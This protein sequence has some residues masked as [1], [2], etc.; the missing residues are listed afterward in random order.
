M[1]DDIAGLGFRAIYIQADGAPWGWGA[2]H[3]RA[4]LLR[5]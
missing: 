4:G 3:H 5:A 2:G 1:E